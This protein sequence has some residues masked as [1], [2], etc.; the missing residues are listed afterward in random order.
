MQSLANNSVFAL[1]CDPPYGLEFMGKEWDRLE[2]NR[3]QQRWAGTERKLIGDGT[4]NNW[5][6][7]LPNYRPSRNKKCRICSHYRFSGTPCTCET[8]DW[9][10]RQDDHVRFMQTWHEEWLLEARRI[11]VPGG[12]A[13]IF[14]GSKTCHRLA[15]AMEVAGFQDIG[16]VGWCYGN[17]F[18]KNLDVSK[19]VD[20]LSLTGKTNSKGIRAANDARPKTGRLMMGLKGS[21]ME[22]TSIR[23]GV[24]ITYEQRDTWHDTDPLTEGGKTFNGYGTA[25]KPAWEPILTGRA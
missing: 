13:R 16:L 20:A 6:G 23:E 18:P 12:V 7:E 19:A 3:N 22:D 8:P 1:V 25:L 21:Y 24:H 11:L 2:P 17:G 10:I 4:A 15:M 5:L 14:S 9:D